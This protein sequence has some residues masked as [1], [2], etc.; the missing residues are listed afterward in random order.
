MIKKHIYLSLI[1]LINVNAYAMEKSYPDIEKVP[2]LSKTKQPPFQRIKDGTYTTKKL[3]EAGKIAI[4]QEAVW[5]EFANSIDT[6]TMML[7][8]ETYGPLHDDDH[9]MKLHLPLLL[10]SKSAA[11]FGKPINVTNCPHVAVDIFAFKKD[12]KEAACRLIVLGKYIARLKREKWSTVG[13]FAEYGETFEHTGVREA[14]EEAHLSLDPK[15]FLLL[16]TSSSP[17]RDPRGRHVTS[18][19]F[20]CVTDQLPQSSDEAQNVYLMTLKGVESTKEEDW[21]AKDFKQRAISAFGKLSHIT[22]KKQ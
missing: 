19:G 13:G 8:K 20:G 2:L 17:D 16:D 4:E 14:E 5:K 3:E 6:E 9:F 1:L 22:E 11:R 7:D 15:S 10:A 18:I 12:D 21:C